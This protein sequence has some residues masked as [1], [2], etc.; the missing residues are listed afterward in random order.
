MHTGGVIAR[1]QTLPSLQSP[2]LLHLSAAIVGEE[3]LAES[4]STNDKPIFLNIAFLVI[5][6]SNNH[7]FELDFMSK[8][9]MTRATE[10]RP[11]VARS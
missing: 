6:K 10:S 7:P 3:I 4:M 11:D 9:V 5:I 8:K 1:I 2:S